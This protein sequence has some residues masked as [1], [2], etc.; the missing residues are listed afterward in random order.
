MVL[1]AWLIALEVPVLLRPPFRQELHCLLNVS[2]KDGYRLIFARGHHS[3]WLN[4]ITFYSCILRRDSFT[5]GAKVSRILEVESVSQGAIERCFIAAADRAV[6]LILGSGDAGALNCQWE[7]L[8]QLQCDIAWMYP[9][10][11]AD[12]VDNSFRHR[13]G[14]WW[15]SDTVLRWWGRIY[16]TIHELAVA[17]FEAVYEE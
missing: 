14:G 8:S 11:S 1:L 17:I 10:W 12:G 3:G 7:T 15:N 6:W 13:L 16:L 5:W 9:R 4:I 2:D